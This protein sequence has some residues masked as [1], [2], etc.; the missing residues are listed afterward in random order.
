MDLSLH[1]HCF[2]LILYLVVYQQLHGIVAPL[3]ED[4]LVGLSWDRVGEGSSEART[5]ASFQPKT[6]GEGKD[7]AQKGALDSPVHVVGAHREANLKSV[8]ILGLL[9]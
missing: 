1:N 7:F 4:E 5:R 3:N 2:T 8:R 9:I 6:D